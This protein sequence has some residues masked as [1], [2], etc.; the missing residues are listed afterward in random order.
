MKSTHRVHIIRTD[1]ENMMLSSYISTTPGPGNPTNARISEHWNWPSDYYSITQDNVDITF[2]Q[3]GWY[4]MYTA[5][6]IGEP[7]TRSLRISFDGSGAGSS[8][9][10][11]YA[12]AMFQHMPYSTD[13]YFPSPYR[14]KVNQCCRWELVNDPNLTHPGH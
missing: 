7:D 4:N 1:R 5:V 12:H 2:P 8:L 3:A 11:G 9:Y 14:R 13:Y 6:A 10:N